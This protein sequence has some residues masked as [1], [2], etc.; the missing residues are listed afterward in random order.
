MACWLSFL[1]PLFE[2]AYRFTALSY[3]PMWGEKMRKKK[4][5]ILQFNSLKSTVFPLLILL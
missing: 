4:K 5:E 1:S 2:G 3:H